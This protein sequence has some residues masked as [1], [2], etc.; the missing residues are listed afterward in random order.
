[1]WTLAVCEAVNTKLDLRYVAIIH[2]SPLSFPFT[3]HLL[4]CPSL[5][6]S[7]HNGVCFLVLALVP[8]GASCSAS[9]RPRRQTADFS[10]VVQQLAFSGVQGLSVPSPLPGKWTYQGCYT[11]VSAKP[12]SDIVLRST[13]ARPRAVVPSQ[14]HRTST[15]LQ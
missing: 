7:I 3:L 1:M 11:Y 2:K 13:T 6:T 15:L 14:V 9:I 12:N 10:C 4:A 8:V 5:E